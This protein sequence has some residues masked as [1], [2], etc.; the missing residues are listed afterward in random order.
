MIPIDFFKPVSSFIVSYLP[1]IICE[2]RFCFVGILLPSINK[3]S[4]CVVYK[5]F[6]QFGK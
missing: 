3:F 2:V 6:I 4:L 1:Q 5:F